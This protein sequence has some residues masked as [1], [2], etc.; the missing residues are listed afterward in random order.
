M[1][2][3]TVR[4]PA[5]RLGAKQREKISFIW[6]VKETLRDHYKRHQY[7]DVILPF[8]V[9]RRL[10]CVLEPTKD[11]VVARATELGPDKWD[12]ATHVLG[13]LASQPFWNASK[14]TFGSLL[15]DQ[16]NIRRNVHAYLRGF[17]PNAR[18]A[19]TRFGLPNQI[20]KMAEAEILYMVVKQ[21][22]E[23]DL[24]PDVVSNLEMGY[25]YEE[26]I[27]VT[28]DL[29]NEEAGEHFTPREV[30]ELMVNVLFADEDR[31]LA[32]GKIFTVYDPACGTGGMLS[33]AEEHLRAMNPSARMHLFGQEVQPE[34]YAVCK[35][36]MLLK[37]QVNLPR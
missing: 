2:T 17:S 5:A 28:A 11:K 14:F 4:T 6:S 3:D 27:R 1:S 31:L 32:P 19:L 21:F 35:T 37:G 25:I 30:I 29:S 34:S 24:H 26:L 8:S 33:V 9:L 22:A 12:A 7:Q 16:H 36:D 15:A 18:D 13:H 20:D 23:I 10:D